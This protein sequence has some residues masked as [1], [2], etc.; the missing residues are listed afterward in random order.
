MVAMDGFFNDE[1]V[2]MAFMQLIDM[3]Y[4]VYAIQFTRVSAT[5]FSNR[6][7]QRMINLI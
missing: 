1:T 4:R 6:A 7:T 5:T 2:N 3:F